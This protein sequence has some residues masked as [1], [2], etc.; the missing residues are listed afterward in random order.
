MTSQ[1]HQMTLFNF[2]F[3]SLALIKLKLGAS[4]YSI[5]L[6][7]LEIVSKLKSNPG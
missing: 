5:S 7:F 1:L 3:G 4:C 2:I 6:I